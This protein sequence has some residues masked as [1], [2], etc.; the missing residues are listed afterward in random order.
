MTLGDKIFQLRKQQGWSQEELAE[1]CQVSRQSVS[2]WEINQSVPDLD[3]LVTLS[4]IFGVTTDYLLKEEQEEAVCQDTGEPVETIWRVSGR[5]AEEYLAQKGEMAVRTAAGTALCVLSPSWLIALGSLAEYGM[6]PVNEDQAGGAGMVLLFL[7]VAAGVYLFVSLE[8]K[9]APWKYLEQDM[10]QLEN[11]VSAWVREERERCAAE[12]RQ[13]TAL[14][15]MLCVLSPV[16][17]FVCMAL[18]SNEVFYG[19]ATALLLAVVAA[20]VYF[21]VAAGSRKSGYDVL[22][23]EGEYTPEKKRAKR[24]R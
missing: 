6:L 12:A 7:L 11:G 1:H 8:G 4:R 14:G 16:P 13:K 3:K 18:T 23:Q 17:L 19:L 10:I 2:K 24:G 9:R 20:G 15:V 5:E 22:L 21:I